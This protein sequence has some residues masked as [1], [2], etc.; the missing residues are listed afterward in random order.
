MPKSIALLVNAV[1][2]TLTLDSNKDGELTFTEKTGP[3]VGRLR[4]K[5]RNKPNV[6]GTVNRGRIVIEQSKVDSV[7]VVGMLPK[8]QYTQVWSSDVTIVT[9]GTE[10]S[11]TELC[12]LAKAVF[13]H[14]DV[15]AMFINGTSLDV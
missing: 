15:R 5:T 2:R 8:V 12:D 11:R 6:A 9:A 10:E 13:S 7:S 1:T 14:D 3:L 4:I